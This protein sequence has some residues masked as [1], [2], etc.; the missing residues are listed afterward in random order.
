MSVAV[1]FA[2]SDSVY[3]SITGCDVYDIYRDARNFGG[4]MPV[5]AHPPCRGW[6]R[7]RHF[8]KPR[9]DELALGFFAV[10]MVRACGGVLEH[11]ESSKLFEA[12]GMPRPV[13]GASQVRD[14]YGGWTFAIDQFQFGHKARK[15][16]WLYVVGVE[17]GELPVFPLVLG[18]AE[19]VCGGTG[20]RSR[21][22]KEITKAER[23]HTPV[24]FAQWL[25][26][27]ARRSK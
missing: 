12:A 23:E 15:K 20:K 17:P 13:K 16:T 6:G 27:L 8:A 1:L 19:F 18:D 10:E 14:E 7:L 11:P 3:K 25:C 2:R 4:G 9:P 5:V 26:E 22:K 21:I 24:E